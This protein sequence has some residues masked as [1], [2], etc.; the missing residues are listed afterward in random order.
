M[1]GY[2]CAF[3]R[4]KALHQSPLSN[5]FL[6]FSFLVLLCRF[7]GPSGLSYRGYRIS[8]L[9][10]HATFNEVA[11]LLLH[12][13]LPTREELKEFQRQLYQARKIPQPLKDALEQLPKESHPMVKKERNRTRDQE[14]ARS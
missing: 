3:S 2:V 6:S 12:G 14:E 5:T 9:S 4:T 13:Y 1:R 7:I 11:F 10:Q 8:D